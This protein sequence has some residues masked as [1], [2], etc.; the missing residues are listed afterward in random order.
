LK[1]DIV[2]NPLDEMTEAETV[3]MQLKKAQTD[4]I[5]LRDSV[6]DPS[7]VRE[8]RFGGDKYSLETKLDKTI[9]PEDLK[10]PT[11]EELMAIEVP[12]EK[13]EKIK[14]DGAEWVYQDAT[15]GKLR[16]KSRE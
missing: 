14:Q 6:L 4:E 2:P 15:L 9:N 8:S 3:D 11:P 13:E 16:A 10:P 5:Y 7:E 12:P 1:L